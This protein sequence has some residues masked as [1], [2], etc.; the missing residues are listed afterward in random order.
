MHPSGFP[1]IGQVGSASVDLLDFRRVPGSIGLG[2]YGR[3]ARLP[4]DL[5]ASGP[6]RSVAAA[7][8]EAGR[9]LR[10]SILGP[11][12]VH[13]GQRDLTPNARKLRTLLAAL[14]VRRGAVVSVEAL[15]DELWGHQPPPTAL[16]ALRVYVSQLRKLLA[17]AAPQSLIS[18]QPPGYRIEP[19]AGSLDV[20]DFDEHCVR[21]Y[22]AEAAGNLEFAAREYGRALELWRGPA[23]ADVRS[24]PIVSGAALRLDESRMVALERRVDVDLALGRHRDLIG[25]L[26]GLVTVHPL[27]E[28]MHAR[29]MVALHRSGRTREALEVYRVVRQHLLE[30]IGCE[31][32]EDLRK[33]QR[34]VLGVADD[35]GPGQ[36]GTL[37]TRTSG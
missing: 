27:N 34:C 12:A 2:G 4:R 29:L 3:A 1:S 28:S 6:A 31:P 7:D 37:L 10:F 16:R 21:A 9:P 23:L 15:T 25:E 19:A 13:Q 24:G 36:A 22:H 35:C 8:R 5:T 17:S 14:L 33:A 32:G 18:T 11:V 26:R 30:E 20:L